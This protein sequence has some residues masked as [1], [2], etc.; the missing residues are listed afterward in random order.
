MWQTAYFL[1]ER[2][3]SAVSEVD[4]R[5][6]LKLSYISAS[7]G[8]KASSTNVGVASF[9]NVSTRELFIGNKL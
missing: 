3:F 2:G 1:N 5:K 9:L 4:T 8:Q 7:K 6:K